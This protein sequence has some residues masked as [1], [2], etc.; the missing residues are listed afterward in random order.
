MITWF[1]A[2]KVKLTQH[3]LQTSS[4]G[5]LSDH[6]VPGSLLPFDEDSCH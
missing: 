5:R 6:A 1:V 2:G 3:L 4:D